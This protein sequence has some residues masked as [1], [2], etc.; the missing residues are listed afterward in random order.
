MCELRR[1][2]G[3]VVSTSIV[4]TVKDDHTIQEK[5]NTRLV[6]VIRYVDHHTVDIF[7][8]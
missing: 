3:K 8:G 1:Y 6:L 7:S 5:I 4:E 2:S